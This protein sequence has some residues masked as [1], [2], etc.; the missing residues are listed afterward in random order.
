MIRS[1]SSGAGQEMSPLIR[2]RGG[3]GQTLIPIDSRVG[4]A[5]AK[6]GSGGHTDPYAFWMAYY[7]TNDEK[8][9]KPNKA[10][11]HPLRETVALL[12]LSGKTR[13]VDAALRAYLTLHSKDAEPWMY[14]ALAIAIEMNHGT[15]AD[16]KTALNYAADL[17]QKSHNPNFLV[18]VADKMFMKGFFD[19]I[20]PLLDEAADKV[21]HRSEPLV[22]S[23]NLAQKTKDPRRMGEAIDRLLSLG[24]PGQDDYFRTESHNQAETLAKTL[25]EDGRAQEADALLA[26]VT[27]SESRD[28]YIRLTWDG[29][30]DFDLTV[31]EPLGATASYLIPRTV[32][33][34]SMLKNG[35][36]AH[37]EEVYVCP[38]GFDGDY[39]IRI[40]N[41]WVDPA[42]PVT[43]LTLET[44]AHEGTAKEKKTVYNLVPDKLNKAFVVHLS[45]GRRKKVL[46]FIDPAITMMEAQ[47]Q[48][49]KNT[50]TKK[51]AR[52]SST[53]Q[54][55]KGDFQSQQSS[56][57]AVK[58]K[59]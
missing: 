38:R 43:R 29:Q 6:S 18:S 9:I 15:S 25:R 54:P 33:G 30:A 24:W 10:G 40:S 4:S 35:Y 53:N 55:A 59:F 52:A 45:E 2:P 11:E 27:N 12:N 26:R 21:P 49:R 8:K 1:G 14:E 58:P 36:G 47:A 57:D 19:R 23:I 5:A 32:F 20:G 34:G 3:Q 56:K 37:P 22:M 51:G 39:T 46:P 13:D 42:K 48:L 31:E 16:I 41:I 28:L 50:K 7:R 17:A 44:I